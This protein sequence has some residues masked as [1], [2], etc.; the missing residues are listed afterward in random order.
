MTELEKKLCAIGEVLSKF[1]DAPKQHI[2]GIF[3]VKENERQNIQ[4]ARSSEKIVSK[5]DYIGVL[6]T[7]EAAK[8]LATISEKIQETPLISIDLYPE[9]IHDIRLFASETCFDQ[10]LLIGKGDPFF[11]IDK[12][13]EARFREHNVLPQSIIVDAC[14]IGLFVQDGD[15][16]PKPDTATIHIPCMELMWMTEN[17]REPRK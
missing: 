13:R 3:R 16:R 15:G 7:M 4:T 8:R 14:G 6:L 5:V 10:S 17:C 12:K 11:S 9:R 1:N 2:G